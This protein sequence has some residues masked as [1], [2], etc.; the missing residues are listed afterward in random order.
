MLFLALA[1]AAGFHADAM[2]VVN[3]DRDLFQMNYLDPDQLDDLIVLVTVDGK[4]RAFDPGERYTTYGTL[5][6]THSMAGGLREQDG[7]IALAN[8]PGIGYKDTIV[9]RVADLT[10]A[11]DGTVTGSATII[12]TGERALRWREKALEGDEVA[13]KKDFDDQLQPD[14]PPGVILKTDHFLG[15][16][17][18]G[19]NLMVRINVSGSLGTATGKRIFLP[20]SIFS[21]GS[22][23]PFA[24]SHREEP[25]DLHYPYMENDKVTLHLPAG[26]QVESVPADARIDLPQNAVYVSHAKADGQ[27]V[28]YSR[29]YIMANVLYNASEYDKLKG[30]LDDVSNKDRAQAVLHV[31]AA[32]HP[33]P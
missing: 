1:R 27:I 5:H 13:L 14:L 6:W 19:T 17:T 30:F 11:P 31:A 4:E 7:H 32:T 26:F 8:S 18:E 29:S 24:S 3:R 22:S 28:T 25:I 16:D 23:D 2:I 9:Q 15:L 21:A 33:G 12:C 10:L 20:V